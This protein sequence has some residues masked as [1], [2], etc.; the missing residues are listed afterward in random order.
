MT[1]TKL[2]KEEQNEGRHKFA[3]LEMDIPSF[4][5]RID[6]L[7]CSLFNAVIMICDVFVHSA[8]GTR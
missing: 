5:V 3:D 8:F 2:K 4:A 7:Y 6:C 1:P